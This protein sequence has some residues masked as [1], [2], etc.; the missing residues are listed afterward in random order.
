MFASGHVYVVSD[1]TQTSLA[2]PNL[3][4]DH[5]KQQLFTQEK[6]YIKTPTETIEGTGFISDQFLK[7]Y[8]IFKVSGVSRSQ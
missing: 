8:R 5:D 4:W 1:S 7:N 3:M 2:T 6:V